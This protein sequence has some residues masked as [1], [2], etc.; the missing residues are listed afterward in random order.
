MTW[1]T[2]GMS[3]SSFAA[4]T[5]VK[6]NAI[7]HAQSLPLATEAVQKCF[8]VDD[9][10]T[11]ANDPEFALILERNCRRTSI[12]GG[13][14]DWADKQSVVEGYYCRGFH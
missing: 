7:E 5:A 12:N 4:N 3:T 2:F 8:Y 9:C 10:L 14:N 13:V 6:Q 11:S 1:V